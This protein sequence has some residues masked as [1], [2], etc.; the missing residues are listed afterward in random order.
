[1]RVSVIVYRFS[2]RVSVVIPRF[3]CRVRVVVPRF[4][5]RVS[6]VV[7][8]FSC[9]V[10]V[11]VYRFVVL[12]VHTYRCNTPNLRLAGKYTGE[13]YTDNVKSR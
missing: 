5:C 7:A 13:F 12:C 1:M 6:V 10:S 11:V 9:R 4:S 3:S 2:C 8:R